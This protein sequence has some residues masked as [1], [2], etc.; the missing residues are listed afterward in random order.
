MNI[1]KITGFN[2]EKER[3]S[4]SVKR[5]KTTQRIIQAMIEATVTQVYINEGFHRFLEGQTSDPKISV[6]IGATSM[7]SS[8][9]CSWV[10][11]AFRLTV[12]RFLKEQTSDP[13]ILVGIGATS[14]FSSRICSWVLPALRLAESLGLDVE[15]FIA[16]NARKIVDSVTPEIKANS[17]RMKEVISSFCKEFFSTVRVKISIERAKINLRKVYNNAEILKKY[18]PSSTAETLKKFAWNHGCDADKAFIYAAIHPE[19]F[20]DLSQKE[21][22]LS[23]GG[24]PEKHFCIARAIVVKKINPE[25]ENFNVRFI[26]AN[27]LPAYYVYPEQGDF[28]FPFFPGKDDLKKMSPAIRKD[29]QRLLEIKGYLD[30]HLS[31]L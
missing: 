19:I 6:G 5:G 21:F 12:R 13:K 4:I 20:R 23:I 29:F 3:I 9:I 14:R 26:T 7:S 11:S 15:I 30:F 2:E 16:E 1:K 22:T 24:K 28:P 18:L 31:F 27:Q 10:L 17:E 8:R 25:L